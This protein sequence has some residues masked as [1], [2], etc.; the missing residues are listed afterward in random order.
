MT[1]NLDA[2]IAAALSDLASNPKV[3]FRALRPSVDLQ[4]FRDELEQLLP[5]SRRALHYVPV[6][7]ALRCHNADKR[8][9][10][11]D[12]CIRDRRACNQVSDLVDDQGAASAG[13]RGKFG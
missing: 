10:Y 6:G 1:S 8:R 7:T 3:K 12:S 11:N 13:E 2:R 5:T 9:D 4:R